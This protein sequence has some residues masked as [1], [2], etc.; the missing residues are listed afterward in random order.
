MYDPVNNKLIVT[1]DVI[2]DETKGWNWVENGGESND[3]D[4]ASATFSVQFFDTEPNPTTEAGPDSD[5]GASPLSP[6]A[7]PS[8]GGEPHTPPGQAVPGS[9]PSNGSHHRQ[10]L[11][12]VQ[13]KHQEDIG[14][15]QT[16]WIPVMRFRVL[17][18][19]VLVF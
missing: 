1:R 15:C 3:S 7:I 16:Y 4:S 9:V 10:M 14:C 18:T 5:D 13:M 12:K 6:Q 11:L 17:N 8:A 2:F 19:V